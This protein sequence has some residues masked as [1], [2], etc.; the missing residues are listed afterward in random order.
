MPTGDSGKEY[1][2][3]VTTYV[4]VACIVAAS[5]G[6]LFGCVHHAPLLAKVATL[7]LSICR[8]SMHRYICNETRSLFVCRYD[9][10]ITGGVISMVSSPLMALNLLQQSRTLGFPSAD[11]SPCLG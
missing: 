5:G 8:N 9:N 10:G 6:A 3:E 11:V 1:A 7:Q 4:I 2:G